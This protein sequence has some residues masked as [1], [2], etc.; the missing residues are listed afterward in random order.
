MMIHT[1]T[2]MIGRTRKFEGAVYTYAH[3]VDRDGA[4]FHIWHDAVSGNV[5]QTPAK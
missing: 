4:S 1:V 3:T 5:W 2:K